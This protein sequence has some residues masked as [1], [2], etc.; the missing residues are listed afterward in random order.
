[1]TEDKWLQNHVSTK[2]ID[3]QHNLKKPKNQNRISHLTHKTVR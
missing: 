2:R 1:M 3:I